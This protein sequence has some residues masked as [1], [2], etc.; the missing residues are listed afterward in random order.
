MAKGKRIAQ[1]RI[2]P[3]YLGVVIFIIIVVLAATGGVILAGGFPKGQP[4]A[5]GASSGASGVVEEGSSSTASQVESEPGEAPASSTPEENRPEFEEQFGKN[6]YDAAFEQRMVEASNNTQI[7]AVYNDYI[8]IWKTELT[9]VMQ[10]L[11]SALNGEQLAQVQ[12]QQGEWETRI[13]A[14]KYAA[15]DQNG[16]GSVNN[17]QKAEITYNAYRERAKALYQI[18]YEKEPG[19]TIG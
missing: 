14:E 6:P 8:T 12:A 10:K 4:A 7:L 19:F 9:T 15:I 3:F 13:A 2:D 18:L 11:S 17:I 5:E 1:G 16:H